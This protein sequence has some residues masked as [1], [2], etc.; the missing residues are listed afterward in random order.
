MLPCITCGK[1]QYFLKIYGGT[2]STDE[3]K[4]LGLK[5]KDRL[6]SLLFI[7]RQLH[8]KDTLYLEIIMTMNFYIIIGDNNHNEF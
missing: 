3:N 6:N 5:K 2:Q 1:K 8:I 7:V 4:Y